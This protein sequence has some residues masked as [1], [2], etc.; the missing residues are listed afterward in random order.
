M[1]RKENKLNNKI[2]ENK[3]NK[4]KIK[5]KQNKVKSI[6]YNSDIYICQ[7]NSPF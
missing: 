2:K 6:I 4:I 1:E 5:L 3:K 7:I